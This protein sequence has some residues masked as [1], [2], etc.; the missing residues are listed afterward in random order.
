MQSTPPSRLAIFA[1]ILLSLIWGYNWVVMEQVIRDVDSFDFS[2]IRTLLGAASLFLVLFVL[3]PP[4][5][6]PPRAR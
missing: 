5:P 6:W 4:M 1:L 3:R 2:A